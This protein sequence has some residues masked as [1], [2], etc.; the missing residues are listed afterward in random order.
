VSPASLHDLAVRAAHAA[1][2]LLLDR[3]GAEQSGI[4]SKSTR[5]DLV[6]DA[7]RD[8][9]ALIIGM[10]REA[11]PDDGIVA[12]EGSGA[13]STSGIR[14]LVDPLDGT[15]N[16]LW[17]HPHW[18][19]SLAAVDVAGDIAGVVHDPGRGETFS[20]ERG[21]GAWL[22]GSPLTLGESSDLAEALVGTG[23]AY[24]AQERGRQA[25]ALATV[26]PRVRDIRR[27]GSAAL[28]LAWVAAG[29]LDAFFETGLA[30]WDWAAG[31]A[32]VRLAGGEADTIDRGGDRS[33]VMIA[34]RPG[35]MRP[36]RSLLEV[37]GVLP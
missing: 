32:L 31:A 17:G 12:E 10:I 11:R 13:P 21:R 22:S 1:G 18:S 24:G 14:W 30:P 34:T 16:F 33:P 3:F 26:L 37:A 27:A 8:A 9:E 28:D 4:Q 6:S 7:D 29:R 25:A 2:V 19:V 23:F 15:V 35:L 20:A 36:L 5:T